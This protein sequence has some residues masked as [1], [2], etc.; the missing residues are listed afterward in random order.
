MKRADLIQ[1]PFR[2]CALAIALL[3]GVAHAEVLR[4]S[5]TLAPEALGAT[6]A[7][8]A[9]A[10]FDDATN[11][12][13]FSAT[14]AG[15]SGSTTQAHFHCCTTTPFTGN[16]GIAVDSPSLPIPLGVSAGSFSAELDL[17]DATN[18]NPA[19]ITLAGGTS[20]AI[21]LFVQGLVEGRAYLNIHSSTFPGGEIRGFLQEVPEPADLALMGAA[22][23]CLGASRRLRQRAARGSPL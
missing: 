13:S 7:G 21:A 22:L 17:D 23:L 5:T 3:A 11:L 18:F 6:G 12:Y 16:A 15:L 1:L 8:T 19:F 20:A 10:T 2:T 14:F 9:T 4:F